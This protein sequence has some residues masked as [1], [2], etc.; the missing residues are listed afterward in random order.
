MG[1]YACGR[2]GDEYDSPQ[3]L[4]GHKTGCGALPWDDPQLLERLYWE[5]D[6]SLSEIA[7]RWED[8]TREKVTWQFRKHDI[9]LRTR[10]EGKRLKNRGK[11]SVSLVRGRFRLEFREFGDHVSIPLARAIAMAE[12]SLDELEGRHVH[13]KNGCSLD[14]RLENLEVLD[15]SDHH[16]GHAP[17]DGPPQ[18]S[19]E[20]RRQI[21][22]ERD[23][24][25]QGRFV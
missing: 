18:M 23:R 15:P 14:D 11:V 17:D 1:E 7:G 6:M 21:A 10:G 22:A 3:A 16:R 19:S 4:A 5:E 20:Q 9:D 25:E 24:D 2:C 12:H 8:A 13:H